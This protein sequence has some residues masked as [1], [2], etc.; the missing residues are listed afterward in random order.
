MGTTEPGLAT[1]LVGVGL[2]LAADVFSHVSLWG[3]LFGDAG[4]AASD[5]YLLNGA[6]LAD[7]G[8]G[9]AL[10]GRLYDRDVTMRL[11]APLAVQ[12]PG[13]AG[14]GGLTSSHATVAARWTFS[15]GDLW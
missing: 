7:A 10:R 6:F 4:F 5:T 8:A 1:V 2:R 15:F 12:Q 3:S 9:L 13:L 14:G 11:D